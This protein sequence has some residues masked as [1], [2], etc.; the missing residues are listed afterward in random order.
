MHSVGI[1]LDRSWTYRTAMTILARP[2]RGTDAAALPPTRS[3]VRSTRSSRRRPTVA[4]GP[5]G[6]GPSMAGRPSGRAWGPPAD[7]LSA[8]SVGRPTELG[9]P[10]PHGRSATMT[11]WPADRVVWGI[12]IRDG[13]DELDDPSHHRGL[14]GHAYVPGDDRVAICGYRPPRRGLLAR[15]PAKL[16]C[17]SARHNPK[18]PRCARRVVAPIGWRIS[19]GRPVLALVPVPVRPEPL[20]VPSYLSATPPREGSRGR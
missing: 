16:G 18:C 19:T 6:A 20:R 13:Y 9:R 4:V 5:G 14:T 17:P 11:G 2:G 3:G 10:S 1:V 7:A 8:A 12:P 15:R